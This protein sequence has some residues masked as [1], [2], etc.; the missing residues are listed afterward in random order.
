MSISEKD[1]I[2][3]SKNKLINPFT[4]RPIVKN[5]PTYTFL[6]KIVKNIYKAVI[7]LI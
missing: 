7:V 4:N 5:G 3:W 2:E 1:C 6:M